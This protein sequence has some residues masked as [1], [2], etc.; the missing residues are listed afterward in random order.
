MNWIDEI[1]SGYSTGSF[2]TMIARDIWNIRNWLRSTLTEA[3]Y[4]GTQEALAKVEEWVKTCRD[5]DSVS[6]GLP[7]YVGGRTNAFNQVLHHLQQLKDNK[8]V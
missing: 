1:V 2:S 6:G 4:R 7:G 8:T 5:Y 3:H